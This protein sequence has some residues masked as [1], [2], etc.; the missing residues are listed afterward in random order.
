MVWRGE[1]GE[2]EAVEG[3]ELFLLM[4]RRQRWGGEYRKSTPHPKAAGE[5]VLKWKQLQGL[6][7]KG[8]KE[9]GE[10][11]NSIKILLTGGHRVWNSTARY[12][13]VLWWE[14]WI[15]RRRVKSRDLRATW[16]EAVPLL[17]G[18][19][20]G[21][22]RPPQR[23]QWTLE[24]NHICWCWNK[25]VKGEAWCQTCIVIFHNP[26][27]A[28]ATRSRELFLGWAG[29]QPQSLGISSSTVPW[30]FVGAAGTQPLLSE[31]LPQRGRI[32][33]SHSPSEVRGLE[34]QPHLR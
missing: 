6:N 4:E 25:V 34:K 2:R 9:K 28:A 11:L 33:Q 7:K 1:L 10:G 26:W 29:T 8:R 5:K 27:N 31:T 23:P 21:A 13:V 15:P 18:H 14:G 32:G 24:N 30:T 17:R 16:G 12:L 19:F 22:V 3:R 20:V